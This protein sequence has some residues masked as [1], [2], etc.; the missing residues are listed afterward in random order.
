MK[1]ITID[2]ITQDDIRILIDGEA[3]KNI[4]SFTL[5]IKDGKAPKCVFT[6]K[7]FKDKKQPKKVKKEAFPYVRSVPEA[8]KYL[9]EQDPKTAIT[10]NAVEKLIEQNKISFMMDGRIRKVNVNEIIEYYRNINSTPKLKPIKPK[11]NPIT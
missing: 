4:D 11:L 5:K 3:V 2:I 7:A 1:N 10:K 9:K 8:I 6:Q